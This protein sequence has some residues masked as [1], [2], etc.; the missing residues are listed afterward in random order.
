MHRSTIV[1]AVAVPLVLAASASATD[2]V[3]P[4]VYKNCTAFNKKY[5]HGVGKLH[6]RDLTKSGDNP[7]TTFKRS[8]R[9]YNLAMS[10]NKGLDRDHDGVA[11]E[12]A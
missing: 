8:T 11:C 2:R 9:L 4:A 10:Y 6:A 5:P 7:V 1:A 3:I 12:K